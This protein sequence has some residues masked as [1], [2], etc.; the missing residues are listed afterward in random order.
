MDNKQDIV[1]HQSAGRPDLNRK[2]VR[3]NHHL[4]MSL[5]E[6]LPGGVLLPLRCRIN[7]VPFQYILYRVRSN[8][9][10]EIGESALNSVVAPG[11]ILPRQ[12]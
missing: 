5:Q 9:V 8:D 4:P 6:I 1:G 10:T 7:A 2:E 12:A 3:G 11:S